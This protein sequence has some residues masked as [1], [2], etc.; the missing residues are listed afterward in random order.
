LEDITTKQ[1]AALGTGNV[2]IQCL[3]E[4]IAVIAF[5]ETISPIGWTAVDAF[6]KSYYTVDDVVPSGMGSHE[7]N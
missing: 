4:N 6:A 3:T 1:L 7:P 5:E 2:A